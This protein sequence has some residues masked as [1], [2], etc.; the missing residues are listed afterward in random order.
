MHVVMNKC[1]LLNPEKKLAQIRLV[2]FEKNKK[3]HT[4]FPKND[5]IEPKAIL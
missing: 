5:V 1:F 3:T 4:L 2:V